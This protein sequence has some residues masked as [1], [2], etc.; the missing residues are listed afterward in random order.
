M[1][2]NYGLKSWIANP[3]QLSVLWIRDTL[4]RIRIHGSLTLTYGSKSDSESKSDSGSGSCSFHQRLSKCPQKISFF[5]FF[6]L[7]F[8]G[9][10]TS[11]SSK[12]KSNKEVTKQQISINFLPLLLNNFLSG[13]LEGG[14]KKPL[15][16]YF[17]KFYER[18]Y[19]PRWQ[20]INWYVP[21]QF[22][23]T[24]QEIHKNFKV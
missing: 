10:F 17:L 21:T 19:Y 13:E 20:G 5:T 22:L 9:T 24:V 16:H 2:K 12:I 18:Y 8:E 23:Y 14:V 1:V 6:L 4:V 3:L 15:K 7:L 11:Q